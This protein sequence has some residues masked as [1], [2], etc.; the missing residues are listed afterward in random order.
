MNASPRL[1]ARRAAGPFARLRSVWRDA[2]ALLLSLRDARVSTQSRLIVVAAVA[3]ALLPIDL[4][5]DGIPLLGITDDL[6][7]VPA[8]LAFAARNLPAPVLLE[9]RSK[10]GRL[11]LGGKI[12]PLAGLGLLKVLVLAGALLALGWHFLAP[13]LAH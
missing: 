10:L 6:L 11:S 9:A 5:P 1:S 13:M 8:V 3:Y 12:A 7:I 4:L 2:A